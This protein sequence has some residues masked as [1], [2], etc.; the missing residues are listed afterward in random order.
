MA[1]AKYP[2]DYN[3]SAQP[4]SNVVNWMPARNPVPSTPPKGSDAAYLYSH[5][6]YQEAAGRGVESPSF[7]SNADSARLVF[8]ERMHLGGDFQHRLAEW[9]QK[10]PDGQ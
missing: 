4:S 6:Q 5:Q 1:T 8:T 9:Q 3:V 7:Q 2:L 10:H